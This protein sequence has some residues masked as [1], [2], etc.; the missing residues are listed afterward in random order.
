MKKKINILI[1]GIGGVTPRSIARSLKYYSKLAD[2][3]IIGIDSNKLALGLY[4][5]ELTDNTYIVPSF[6]KKGYWTKIKKIIAKEKIDIAIVQPEK[7]VEGWSKYLEKGNSVSCKVILPPYKLVAA[8]RDKRKMNKLLEFSSLIPQSAEIKINSSHSFSLSDDKVGY[9]CWVRGAKGTSGVGA[10]KI[11]NKREL[12]AWL[13]IST[14]IK[15]FTLSEFLPGR[16][17]ACKCLYYNGQLLRTACME[18]L[19]YLMAKVAPSGVTGNISFG[20]LINDKKAVD[21]AIKG[22]ETICGKL[23]VKP[24][25]FLTVDLK[26]DKKKKIKITEINAR[27]IAPTS[28]FAAAGINLA[29]EMVQVGMGNLSKIKGPAF[30]KFK[31]KYILLR[32]VDALPIVMEEKKLLKK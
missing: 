13:A 10:L 7:E 30:Y 32:D 21:V 6:D 29:E 20:R 15:E 31:K 22:I 11:N 28:S 19:Q 26:E 2:Y 25:G 16:N 14:G 8:I 9:P 18:R 12:N 1:A 24:H 27:H 4:D 17:L 23:K 5:K 3:R